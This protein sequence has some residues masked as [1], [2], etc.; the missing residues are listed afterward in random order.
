MARSTFLPPLKGQSCSS[1]GLSNNTGTVVQPSS[2]SS[3]LVSDAKH[4]DHSIPPCITVPAHQNSPEVS[5]Q[6]GQSFPTPHGTKKAKPQFTNNLNIKPQSPFLVFLKSERRKVKHEFKNES[7]D[8]IETE[9]K[10]RW[11]NIDSSK[12]CELEKNYKKQM[13]DYELKS[14]FYE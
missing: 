7:A 11:I 2:I 10:K 9:V 12:R 4:S 6:L 13:E 1:S 14:K 3:D 8:F 5:C